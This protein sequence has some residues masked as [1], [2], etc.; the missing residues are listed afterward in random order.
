MS[1][2]YF[3]RLAALMRER[4]VPQA[5]IDTLVG[6]LRAYAEEAGGGADEEFGPVAELAAQ[7]SE[8]ESP[9]SAAA[10][11]LTDV[12]QEPGEGAETWVWTADAFKEQRLLEHFGGQGWEVERLDRLGRFV[13]RRDLGHPMR[14]EYRRETVGHAGRSLLSGQLGPEGWEQCGVWGPFTY[15]KRPGAVLDGPAAR[16]AEP[17]APPHKRVYIGKW[18]YGWIALSLLAAVCAVW[19]GMRIVDFS[20]G[21]AVAGMCVGLALVGGM[22]WAVWRS[23]LRKQMPGGQ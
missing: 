8:R 11:D 16:V 13:C 19:W 15:F 18:I 22:A 6:E 3:E 20:D 14:W 12:S 21:S 9:G 10:T 2:T 23:V 4:E 7:L 1:T 17:P 5:R